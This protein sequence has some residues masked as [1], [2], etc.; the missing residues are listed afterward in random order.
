MKSLP[1]T[2]S[3]K[4]LILRVAVVITRVFTQR[5]GVRFRVRVRIRVRV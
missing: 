3:N 4:L 2:H 1:N 5:D